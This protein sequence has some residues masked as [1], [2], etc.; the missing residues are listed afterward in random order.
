MVALFDIESEPVYDQES[1]NHGA[2][3][4]DFG[5]DFVKLFE[6]FAYDDGEDGEYGPETDKLVAVKMLD[7][8]FFELADTGLL[9]E[10]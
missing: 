8:G 5:V 7:E 10:E 1:L 9:F 4:A 2:V 6:R 3:H